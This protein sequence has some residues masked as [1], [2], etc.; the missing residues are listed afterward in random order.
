M[1][2]TD[3][4]IKEPVIIKKKLLLDFL[5]LSIKENLNKENKDISNDKLYTN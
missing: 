3:C 1:V 5:N 4:K 2:L